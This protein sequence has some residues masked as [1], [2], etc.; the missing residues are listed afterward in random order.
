MA[1]VSAEA[2]TLDKREDAYSHADDSVGDGVAEDGE[3]QRHLP[4]PAQ[5][6]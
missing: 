4:L 2:R 6:P 1:V 5:R 3:K